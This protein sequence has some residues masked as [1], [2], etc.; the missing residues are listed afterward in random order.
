[1]R[2]ISFVANPDAVRTR[3]VVGGGDVDV[4]RARAGGDRL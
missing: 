2:F 1:M 4:R 3:P